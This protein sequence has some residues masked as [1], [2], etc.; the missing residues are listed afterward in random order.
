[1]G[2]GTQLLLGVVVVLVDQM[3]ATPL[4]LVD[5]VAHTAVELEALGITKT[6]HRMAHLP[7]AQSALSA[8]FGVL[9][10]AIRRT[11]QTSN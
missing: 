7:T 4:E 9:A 6:I 3:A 10:V 8:S 11:P 1:M 5:P 2:Q